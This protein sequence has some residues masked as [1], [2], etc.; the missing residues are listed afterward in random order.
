MKQGLFLLN[1]KDKQRRADEPLHRLKQNFSDVEFIESYPNDIEELIHSVE[2]AKRLG[3]CMV[4]AGGGDGTISVVAGLLNETDIPL[5]VLP[6]GT[7]NAFARSMGI[8]LDP[9]EAASHFIPGRVRAV[10]MGSVNGR[11]FLC[12]MSI[13]IDALAVHLVDKR[14]KKKIGKFAYVLSGIRSIVSS[15]SIPCFEFE[16]R[17]C[18]HCIMSNVRNYAGIDMFP[19]NDVGDGAMLYTLHG[20]NN[21]IATLLWARKLAFNK[22]GEYDVLTSEKN[23]VFECDAPV[24]I[25][26]DG[27]AVLFDTIVDA[28]KTITVRVHEKSL[29]VFCA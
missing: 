25:Q 1:C 9:I 5:L 10:D 17:P 21:I 26:I 12:F 6:M 20:S 23:M 16:K 24:H 22:R 13:G 4:V 27:E 11:F 29:K 3:V 8:P 14:V 7:V 28:K 2:E 15:R 19:E 18:Y